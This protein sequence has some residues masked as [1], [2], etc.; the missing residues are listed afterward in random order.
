MTL[1]NDID[2]KPIIR[3]KQSSRKAIFV[4]LLIR[5]EL[6]SLLLGQKDN[7]QTWQMMDNVIDWRLQRY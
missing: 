1:R 6:V 4:L 2:F 3:F 5:V 7:S